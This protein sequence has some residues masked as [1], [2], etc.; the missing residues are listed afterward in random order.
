MDHSSPQLLQ[1]RC[2]VGPCSQGVLRRGTA[3][4]PHMTRVMKMAQRI[5]AS[6]EGHLHHKLP[7]EKIECIIK[8][9]SHPA[10][11]FF[12]FLPSGTVGDSGQTAHASQDSGVAPIRGLSGCSTVSMCNNKSVHNVHNI[13]VC[14]M[15]S[16]A[17]LLIQ[18]LRAV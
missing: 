14:S 10:L 9:S 7:P 16:S 1:V 6:N 12:S 5:I 13:L 2:R 8:D 15:H 4:A 18:M 3:A 11:S 17:V